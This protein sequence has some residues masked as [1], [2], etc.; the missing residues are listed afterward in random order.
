MSV[1]RVFYLGFGI[2]LLAIGSLFALTHHIISFLVF[3]GILA[4]IGIYDLLQKKHTI[5]RNFPILG[6]ARFFLEFI[7]PEIRQYIIE[8]DE[9][10]R[11]FDRETRAVIY[12]RSKYVRDTVPFGTKRDILKNGYEW[13]LHSLSPVEEAHVEPRVDVG[14]P[15]CTQP[16]NASRLNIS[17]LSFGA[18]SQNAILALNMGAKLGGFAHNTGEGGL[19][20]YHLQGGGDIIWQIGTGYFGCRT[21]DGNFDEKLFAQKSI[22]KNVVMIEIKLSQ[23][24]KP[25]HGGILPA[26]KVDA[27]IAR[28]RGLPVGQDVISP[29]AH[30]AFN[31]PEGLLHFVDKLRTLSGGKPIGFKLCIGKKHEFLGICKAM[32]STKIL[33]DFITVDGAE[34]GTGAAPLEYTNHVGTPLD[35]GLIFVNNALTGIGVRDQI[36]IIASGKVATGFNM[37]SKLALGADMC[38][39]ARAMMLALGCIQSMQCNTNACPTGV[40]TQDKRLYRGL[41]VK[42]KKLRVANFH[43]AT[44]ESFLSLIAAMGIK[45]P[46]ELD[47]AHIMRRL[48]QGVVKNYAEIYEYLAP[49]ELLKDHTA[50]TYEFKADWQRACADSFNGQAS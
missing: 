24:A 7:G 10:E 9:S 39:C 4:V 16:Y 11:P 18:L 36:K 26:A 40:A 25:S 12:Q 17:A 42:D 35:D 14:G 6:R 43:A 13:S 29:P 28:I 44:M 48:T 21:S 20:D 45:N 2:I 30:T 38:N 1:R 41:D 46:D 31:T 3:L 23:G 15:Q 32:L 19:S 5:L 22:L 37:V 49:G 8:D 27:E 50:I 33:P 34:G 47:P